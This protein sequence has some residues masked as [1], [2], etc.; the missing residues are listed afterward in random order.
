MH[1]IIESN[2]V[3]QP[4]LWH[5]KKDEEKNKRIHLRCRKKKA[6]S[7]ILNSNENKFKAR[8]GTQKSKGWPSMILVQL[9]CLLAFYQLHQQSSRRLVFPPPNSW[10]SVSGIFCCRSRDY[11]RSS[12]HPPESAGS[13]RLRLLRRQAQ[14]LAFQHWG[15][16]RKDKRVSKGHGTFSRML[17]ILVFLKTAAAIWADDEFEL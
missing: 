1:F 3:L 13:L 5:Y 6:F 4:L 12:P 9:W 14:L 7:S 11:A 15:E 16:G 17:H 10:L 8:W 2:K